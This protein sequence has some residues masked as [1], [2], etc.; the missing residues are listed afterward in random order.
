MLPKT[1]SATRKFTYDVQQIVQ[2]LVDMDAD[3][4]HEDVTLEQ[5]LDI[6][7]D[8]VYDDFRSP[9]EYDPELVDE[10]GNVLN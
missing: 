3:L 8:W 2:E 4:S 10:E 7:L 5:V 9:V 1:I 6:V